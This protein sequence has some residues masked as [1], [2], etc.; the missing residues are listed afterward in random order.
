M[1]PTLA[2]Q[3]DMPG[4]KVYNL[5]WGDKGGVRQRGITQYTISSFQTKAAPHWVR[6]YLFNGYRRLSGEL[7]FFGVPMVLGYSV[8]AWAKSYD[9]FQ[10]SKAGHIANGGHHD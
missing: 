1:R 3:G 10:N 7:L 8:Y 2:R 4:G 9:E 5:W 6:S